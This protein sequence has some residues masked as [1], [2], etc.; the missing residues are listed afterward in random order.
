MENYTVEY[1]TIDKDIARI[2]RAFLA[3][4]YGWMGLGLLLTA[5]VSII[6]VSNSAILEAV[7]GTRITF[8]L[9]LVAE[10][11]VVVFLSARIN[12]MSSS[13][14]AASFIIYAVLNGLTLSVIFLVY[15]ASS[16]ASTFITAAGMFAVMAVF[17]Y[18]TKRDLNGMGSFMMMGLIGIVIASFVNIFLASSGLSWIISFIGVIVF[19]GLTAYDTQKLKAMAYVM[20]EGNEA[21]VKGSIF[22][23]LQLYLDFINLFLFLL[24]L[25]GDRR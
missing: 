15:T 21:A 9:L 4:V 23:A 10:L 12:R 8:L 18:T 13:A 7:I 17:G 2:Q 19:T 11:G 22:G 5:L 20:T 16:I 24:R 3:K 1:A 6:T 25:L 14:A